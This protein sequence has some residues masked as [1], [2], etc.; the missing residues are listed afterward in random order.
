MVKLLLEHMAD[1]NSRNER[2]Q[3]PLHLA[4]SG[5]ADLRV[6]K[7]LVE[8]GSKLDTPDEEGITP[9]RLA[10]I[11]GEQR[12]YNWLVERSGGQE[13]I[14]AAEADDRPFAIAEVV[15]DLSSKE[16]AARKS[17]IRRLAL[18][19]EVAMPEVLK[20]IEAGT[21]IELFY[22]AF[23]AMGPPAETAIPVIAEEFGDK[24]HALGW[25]IVVGRMRPGAID[26]LPEAQKR[27]AAASLY[28]VIVD[29]NSDVMGGFAA[30]ALPALGP[31]AVPT[32]LRLLEREDS[33]IRKSMARHVADLKFRDERV[34]AKLRELLVKDPSTKVRAKAAKALAATS[35]DDDALVRKQLLEIIKQPPVRPPEDASRQQQ[36]EAYET[37]MAR[38][39]A[40]GAL[41]A[42]GPEVIDD[43]LPLLTPMDGPH[44]RLAIITLRSLDPPA[45]P[46]LIELLDHD[47]RAIAI[48]ASIALG[49]MTPRAVPALVDLLKTGN[50]PAVV[51]SCSVLSGMGR[52]AEAA[53]KTLLD[54]AGS[55]D[56]SD[57]MRLAAARAALK[58]SP[59]AADS[60]EIRAAMSVLIRLLESGSFRQQGDAANAL[61]AIG[62]P[63]HEALPLLRQRLTLP[64]EGVDTQ[65]LVRD[66]I[67]RE[68]RAAIDAIEK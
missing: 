27:R 48:S 64:A 60:P 1:P 40:A 24:Q 47:D 12:I 26:A 61:G 59:A 9:V 2:R 54:V 13:P 20:T 65:G 45:I 32:I 53:L 41:A 22:E 49:S 14:P 6:V 52:G 68:A 28:E 50:E 8:A 25:L 57:A 30:Q 66:Y 56:R 23:P 63:A 5:D 36:A 18:N 35:D 10:A 42:F 46:R 55:D 19:A 33:D 7:L 43:L 11:R 44:R 37:Y 67:Q 51:H 34:I 62:P 58:I 4:V 39:E 31:S 16:S 15:R 17:A 21:P 38:Q 3:T 29:P